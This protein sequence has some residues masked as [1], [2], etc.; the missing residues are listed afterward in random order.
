MIGRENRVSAGTRKT[1]LTQNNPSEW[2]LGAS[3][4]SHDDD[5]REDPHEIY[6]RLRTIAPHLHDAGYGRVLLTRYEDVRA[7]LRHDA[8]S[9]D[10]RGSRPESY[11]RRIAGTGVKQ[12][13]GDTAYEPPLVLLDDPSHRRIRG[14]VSKAFTPKAVA[15]MAPRIGALVESLL[16]RLIDQSTID[17]IADFAGPLPT[18]VIADMMGLPN[19]M[20]A[21]FK[22]WS[23]EILMGYDPER[24]SEVNNALRNAYRALS[25]VIQETVANRRNSPQDDLITGMVEAQEAGDRL[26][27]LEIISL[28]TQLMVAGNVTTTDL[29]GNGLYALLTHPA[30]LSALLAEPALIDQAVE[31]MLRFD[32]PL[33]ETA[34]IAT[35]QLE[36]N[37]CPIA[38]ADTL[39]LS[40]AAANHDPAYFTKPHEF[41]LN[42]TENPHLAF[43]GGIHVCLGAPLARLEARIGIRKFLERFP[44]VRF[45]ADQPQRRELPF[46]RGFRSFPLI[47][48]EP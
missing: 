38:P 21:D 40:M 35:E 23:E 39:T 5:F 18:R 22:R 28:C 42:R 17:F 6:D 45:A 7:A 12:N 9:V 30:Q 32:C 24:S 26:T 19:E 31:E 15:A 20:H 46:F 13:E 34:R 27:D 47:L 8:L 16:N 2:P 41:D 1:I 14:L 29:I 37:E 36:L 33:T 11:T 10:A 3:L 48:I 25:R 43:G 44:K 4:C